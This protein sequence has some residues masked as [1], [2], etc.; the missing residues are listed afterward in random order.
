MDFTNLLKKHN[1]ELNTYIWMGLDKHSSEESIAYYI[2]NLHS[3]DSRYFVTLNGF[4][5]KEPNEYLPDLGYDA[6]YGDRF[7]VNDL[8]FDL[9]PEV[10]QDLIKYQRA[11]QEAWRR[12]EADRFH[13]FGDLIEAINYAISR[14]AEL[15]PPTDRRA[16]YSREVQINLGEQFGYT[17][18]DVR[19][20]WN[21]DKEAH[22]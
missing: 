4:G 13:E 16:A 2:E 18:A 21:R 1:L 9:D 10:E 17:L 20:S 14:M 15:D 7:S 11:E 8:F 3:D 19:Y 12:Y 5:F 6:N 22:S